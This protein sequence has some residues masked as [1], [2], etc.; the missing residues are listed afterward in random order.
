MCEW[1]VF[2]LHSLSVYLKLS[3]RGAAYMTAKRCGAAISGEQVVVW[4]ETNPAHF[5]Y[6]PEIN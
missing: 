5:Q 6:H 2:Y 3:F 1:T 4:E